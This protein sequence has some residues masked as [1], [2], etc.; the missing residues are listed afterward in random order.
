MKVTVL[1]N[2]AACNGPGQASSGYLVEH[3]NTAILLDCGTGVF[4]RLQ[5]VFPP[6]KL[7]AV[8]ISHT[9]WDHSCDLMP[10]RYLLRSIKGETKP[11]LLLPPGGKAQ[12]DSIGIT[13]QPHDGAM[14]DDFDTSE[15]IPGTEVKVGDATLSFAYMLHYGLSCAIRVDTPSGSLVFSGDTGPNPGLAAFA[16]GA[17]LF[18]C[19]AS[20]QGYKK[21]LG[22][23]GHLTAAEAGMAAQKA[24]VK[25]LLLT[26]VWHVLDPEVSVQE[27]KA[28]FSG[29][30]GWAREGAVFTV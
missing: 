28:E 27:A 20:Y 23:W 9:H 1:G 19:E 3:E 17:D 26:H 21:E 13:L 7:S 14:T 11:R 18:L 25:K 4:A 29:P 8:A 6:E 10:F 16:N 24:G 2:G 30:V 12:L 5:K 15:Y 22:M